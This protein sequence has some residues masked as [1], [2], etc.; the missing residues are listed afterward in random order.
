MARSAQIFNGQTIRVEAHILDNWAGVK[1]PIP[2]HRVDTRLM[3]ANS[4]QETVSVTGHAKCK[5]PKKS[6][7]WKAINAKPTTSDESTG[8]D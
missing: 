6:W 3:S 8:S 7:H 2:K 5:P 1:M 4:D